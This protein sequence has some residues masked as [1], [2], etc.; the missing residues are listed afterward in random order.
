[1]WLF[2]YL[3]SGNKCAIFDMPFIRN[4]AP[5]CF[6]CFDF[7]PSNGASGGLLVVWCSSSFQGTVVEKKL[8]C[9]S[10]NFVALHN[11]DNWS[12]TNIYGSCIEPDRSEF[13]TWFKDCD[14]SDTV[15]WLFL[16]DF[17][18]Y[19]SL[20][21]RNKPGGNIADTI[22]FSDAIDHLG[23]IELPLKGRTYN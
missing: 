3:S 17:N 1:M 22:T 2:D 13:I 6:D 23:L 4:F 7:V 20:D 9:I 14:V 11:G 5:C 8:F 16:G 21:N 15:N 19:R 12:L 18:F 10:V